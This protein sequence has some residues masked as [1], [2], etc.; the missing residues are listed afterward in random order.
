MGGVGFDNIIGLPDLTSDDVRQ[1]GGSWYSGLSCTNGKDPSTGMRTSAAAA[2][3]I[4]QAFKGYADYDDGLPVVC[5][6]VVLATHCRRDPAAR[7]HPAPVPAPPAA[8]TAPPA[9]S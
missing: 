1:A 9:P 3:T 2:D 8:T 7:R 6:L 5:G 4:G